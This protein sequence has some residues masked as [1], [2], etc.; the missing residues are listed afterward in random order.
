M[1][2]I[3][4]VRVLLTS[5]YRTIVA[6]RASARQLA[7]SA[8]T[9]AQ[10]DVVK[11]EES[12]PQHVPLT[13]VTTLSAVARSDPPVKQE[14]RSLDLARFQPTKSGELRPTKG[15]SLAKATPRRHSHARSAF[16]LTEHQAPHPNS[17]H[18]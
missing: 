3:D 8:S 4:T 17:I 2:Y 1:F 18:A 15:F 7:K 11:M 13:V 5:L 16:S 12:E 14:V 10:L 9:S 6:P